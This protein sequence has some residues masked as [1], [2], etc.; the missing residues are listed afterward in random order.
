MIKIKSKAYDTLMNGLIKQQKRE[1]CLGWDK[2]RFPFL[3]LLCSKNGEI[4]DHATKIK[5]NTG[6]SSKCYRMS[7]LAAREFVNKSIKMMKKGYRVIGL[8][9]VGKFTRGYG[10]GYEDGPW[11]E[12]L[13]EMHSNIICVTVDI[14]NIYAKQQCKYI[15]IGVIK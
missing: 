10:Y 6:D 12:Q 1:K 8:A 2:A 11:E 9:R 15:Q 7:N 14:N 13:R 3:Y 5:A 4:I